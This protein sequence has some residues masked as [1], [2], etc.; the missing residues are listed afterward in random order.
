MVL[1]DARAKKRLL[2]VVGCDGAAK[3]RLPSKKYQIH[4]IVGSR[5]LIHLPQMRHGI[6]NRN[7]TTWPDTDTRLNS[8]EFYEPGINRKID[9]H[10]MG[11]VEAFNDLMTHLSQVGD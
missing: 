3:L 1:E 5:T 6:P 4:D 8:N 9:T 10:G 11:G 7:K 2:E